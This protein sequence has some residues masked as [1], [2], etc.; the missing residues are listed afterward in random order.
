MVREFAHTMCG[1][2]FSVKSQTITMM[3]FDIGFEKAMCRYVIL[4]IFTVHETPINNFF[5]NSHSTHRFTL[6]MNNR[7]R[8]NEVI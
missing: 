4:N 3:N 8:Y 7:I 6:K 2:L 1:F 5:C